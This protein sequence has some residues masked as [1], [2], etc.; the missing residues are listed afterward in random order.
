MSE[1]NTEAQLETVQDAPVTATDADSQVETPEAADGEDNAPEPEQPKPKG[2]QKRIDEL[3]FKAREA[4]RQAAYWRDVAMR[5]QPQQQQSSAYDYQP[6]GAADAFDVD[7]IVTRKLQEREILSRA[8]TFLSGLND[9]EA[10]DFVMSPATPIFS[11]ELRDLVLQSDVGKE[12]VGWFARNQSEYDKINRLPPHLLGREV[13]KIEQSL[14]RQ[15]SASVL[16]Q[17]KAPAPAP[18]LGSK[19]VADPD[20]EAMSP[21]D[22]LKWRN[23]TKKVL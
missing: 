21:D 3:T 13:A 5:G 8:E 18:T 10:R 17:T 16:R 15:P 9:A 2:A 4:E 22:W 1:E 20:T 23:K 19:S 6:S 11:N 14:R 12:V 7:D